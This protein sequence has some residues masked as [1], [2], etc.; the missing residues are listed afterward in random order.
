MHLSKLIPFATHS[1][2]LLS[3][4]SSLAPDYADVKGATRWTT[5]RVWKL[6]SSELVALNTNLTQYR[7][8]L[9]QQSLQVS[10]AQQAASLV[11]NRTAG[12]APSF[13]WTVQTYDLQLSKSPVFFFWLR[14]Y[15]SNGNVTSAYFN[16]TTEITTA[17]SSA[18]SSSTPP[19]PTLPS[20]FE[21]GGTDSN[22]TSVPIPTLY[23]RQHSQIGRLILEPA[24]GALS[25][26]FRGHRCWYLGSCYPGHGYLLVSLERTGKAEANIGDFCSA[27]VVTRSRP[28]GIQ[29]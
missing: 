20:G 18:S 7:I 16:I 4:T 13:Y 3:G 28:G 24:D 5:N 29:E 22:G 25:G 1:Q 15:L 19:I 14:D 6:G 10:T 8:E 26:S 12:D 2:A 17:A 11:S 23:A 21:N 9:W 27:N